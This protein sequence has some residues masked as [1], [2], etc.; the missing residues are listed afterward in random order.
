MLGEW[1]DC[2]ATRRKA[3]RRG[4]NEGS[5]TQRP[6]G[7]YEGRLSYQD[8]EGRIR[9]KS[10]Y[11]KTRQDVAIRLNQALADLSKG[12]PPKQG[13]TQ[14]VE[15]YLT[16]WLGRV[17]ITIKPSTHQRYREL[18][19]LH[20]IPFLGRVTLTKLSP[21]QVEHLYAKMIAKGLSHTTVKQAHVI[22]HHA[23]ADAL[24]KGLIVRNVTVL[25][26]APRIIRHEIR[27]LT[28]EEAQRLLD[29]ARGHRLEALF[30]LALT[31]GMRLGE[32]LGT[33]WA[34]VD[35]DYGTLQVRSTLRKGKDGLELGEPKTR[36]SRR[37]LS[38]APMAI[39]A[40]KAHQARQAEERQALGAVWQDSALVFTDAIGRPLSG[41]NVLRGE[42]YP[43]LKRA[44]LPRVRF[45]DLRHSAAS[46][47]LS[48]GVHP[49]VVSAMLGH[50]G[51]AITMDIYSHVTAPLMS[52]ATLALERQLTPSRPHLA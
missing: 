51:I 19:T 6:D 20:V 8:D 34:S 21:D 16:G 18:M 3:T 43:L 41:V 13:E 32:L 27:P 11:G 50:S 22:L 24:R 12:Q 45:H 23:L 29:A 4:N 37:Q 26:D 5:I 15:H 46:L 2:M 39:D 25:V 47:L 28:A 9:R 31:S 38:L 33:R 17:A 30:V 52:D 35:L 10:L 36:Q 1:E 44:G 14:T 49:K 48:Q 7:L 40:L 42:F